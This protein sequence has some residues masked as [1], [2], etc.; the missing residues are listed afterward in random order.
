MANFWILSVRARQHDKI[1]EA[2]GKEVSSLENI[3]TKTQD[4]TLVNRA[5]YFS[6]L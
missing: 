2:G 1:L 4:K 6:S 5:N 3:H